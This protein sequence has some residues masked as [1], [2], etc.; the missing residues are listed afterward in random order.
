VIPKGCVAN[1]QILMV[2]ISD[3][4]E[5]LPQVQLKEGR[6]NFSRR[7]GLKVLLKTWCL[8]GSWLVASL[9]ALLPTPAELLAVDW[10]ESASPETDRPEMGQAYHFIPWQR[11]HRMEA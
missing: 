9:W 8:R 6:S 10:P 11:F 1:S 7:R 3:H 2:G 5:P 4:T